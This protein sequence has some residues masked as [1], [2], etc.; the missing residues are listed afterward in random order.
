[1]TAVAPT[2]SQTPADPADGLAAAVALRKLAD[3]IEDDAVRRAVQKHW[4]WAD[5][6]EALGVTKQAVHQKYGRRM[7]PR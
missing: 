4:S 1:L 5:I 7:G 6:A 2:A 3:R